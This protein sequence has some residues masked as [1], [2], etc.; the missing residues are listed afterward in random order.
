MNINTEIEHENAVAFATV[1]GMARAGLSAPVNTAN[2][3]LAILLPNFD[4]A[5]ISE[6]AAILERALAKGGHR[7]FS[8]R[9][10]LAAVDGADADGEGVGGTDDSDR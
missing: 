1:D 10:T 5:T 6:V 4:D 9:L 8:R 7:G 2:V 3:A